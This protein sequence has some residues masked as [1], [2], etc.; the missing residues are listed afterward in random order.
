MEPKLVEYQ[1]KAAK[2]LGA[3]AGERMNGGRQE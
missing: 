3:T 1:L 2:P